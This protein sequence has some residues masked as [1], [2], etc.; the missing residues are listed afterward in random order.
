MAEIFL[1]IADLHPSDKVRRPIGPDE[2]LD[3][4]EGI[5]DRR[6]AGRGAGEQHRVCAMLFTDLK[7]ARR[8]GGQR[9]IPFH[10]FPAR[11]GSRLGVGTPQRPGQ[12]SS[13]GQ[14]LWRRTTLCAQR[15]ARGMIGIG[16]DFLQPVILCDEDRAATR[17]A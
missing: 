4:L 14:N 16:N 7:K 9:F 1:E 5:A 6:P 10:R 12:P 17:P 11:I 2:G 8:D 15:A 13:V 3:P